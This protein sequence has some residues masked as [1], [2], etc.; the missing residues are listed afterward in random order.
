MGAAAKTIIDSG[1]DPNIEKLTLNHASGAL[2][3]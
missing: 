2:P 3:E 1:Y